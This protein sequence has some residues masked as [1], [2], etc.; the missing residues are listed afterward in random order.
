MIDG[1]PL[2]VLHLAMP[3]EFGGLERV[4]ELLARGQHDAGHRVHVAAL[5]EAGS[6]VPGLVRAL[7]PT[8]VTVH[9]IPVTA[10]GYLAERRAVTAICRLVRP[11][12]IHTHGYR[13]DVIDAPAARRLG[14][15]IVTTVHGRTSVGWRDRFYERLQ[16]R[17]LRRFDAVVAVSRPLVDLLREERIPAERTH[18]IQNA[19]A[20]RGD[21]AGIMTRVDARRVLQVPEAGFRIGWVGRLSHEKG[22]DILIQALGRLAAAGACPDVSFVGDGPEMAAGR[23]AVDA[24]GI[25]SR[26]MWHGPIRDV[27]RLYRAFDLF[28]LSSRREGTPIVLFEAM[29][30]GVPIVATAVGGVPDVISS[31][32][33]RLIPPEAPE[34]LASAIR[35]VEDD[36]GGAA[37][38]S[39]SAAARLTR[40]F[41]IAPWV[42]RYD[43]VYRS[44]TTVH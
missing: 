27:H 21:S 28:V 23:A 36:P 10:R 16:R 34:A 33:A 13:P 9:S 40:E 30:A 38:R 32:D 18:L 2:D 20:D 25:A 44:L 14:C 4:V 19:W 26:I 24:A 12:I 31:D 35:E 8:G 42:A 22:P 17:A 41:A 15:P 43:A 5:I 1:R 29:S 37:T 7:T 3:G 6:P 39:R 11:A